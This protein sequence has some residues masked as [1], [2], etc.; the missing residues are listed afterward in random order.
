[1]RIVGLTG[2]IAAGKS[3]V[4]RRLTSRG[5]TIIDAD[6]LAREAVAVGSPALAAIVAR[7]GPTVLTPEGTLD[8]AALRQIIFADE[9]ERAALEA[10]VH[11]EVSKLR[12]RDIEKARAVGANVVVCDIPLLFEAGLESTVDAIILVDAPL[13]VRRDRL[14]KR[15]GLPPAEADAM[16]AAQ[17]PAEQKRNRATYVIDNDGPLSALDPQ[18]DAIWT[19]LTA[20]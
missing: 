4:A 18:V 17:W 3:E 20:T 5:A 15:R 6:Q 19:A 7:W 1:M 11:P 14:I 2:N 10:I 8:R 12:A 13:D 16:L 9:S